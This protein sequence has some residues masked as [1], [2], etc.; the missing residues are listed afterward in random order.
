LETDWK[1]WTF[2]G[3]A[4]PSKQFSITQ[5]SPTML[6]TFGGW[7]DQGQQSEVF[8]LDMGNPEGDTLHWY[9]PHLGGDFPRPRNSHSTAYC[10]ELKSMVV[11]GGWNGRNYIDDLEILQLD[12]VRPT[13]SLVRLSSALGPNSNLLICIP[14]PY[15]LF[16]Y[17]FI[18]LFIH[19]DHLL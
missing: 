14:V 8:I 10:K 7:D 15:L 12:A 5:I 17:S 1:K 19:L 3:K 4:P 9:K 11:F 18:H 2:T 16:I 6:L 13:D